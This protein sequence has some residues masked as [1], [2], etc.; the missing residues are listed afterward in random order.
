MQ[1]T[2]LSEKAMLVKLTTRR[3]NLS[4]RDEHAEYII[5][6]Q[7]D[8]ASLVVISRLFRDNNNPVKKVLSTLNE[9]YVYHKKHTLPYTDKGPRILPNALYMDYTAEMRAKRNQL[10]NLRAKVMPNYDQY[11][12]QDIAARSKSTTRAKVE[13]YP[14]AEEFDA[15]VGFDLRFMPL[16]DK[17]HFLFDLSDEDVQNFTQAMVDAEAAAKNDA[18]KRMLEPLKHLVDKL[19]KPIGTEG[20]IFR[21]SA[22]ENVIEGT[23]L[24]KKLLIDPPKELLDTINNLTSAVSQYHSEWLRESPVVREQAT[25]KL[26]DIA[27]QMGAFMG[28]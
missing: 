17:K 1:V 23:E 14:T 9:A 22:I 11:V 26:D 15:R 4:K 12:Q 20:S 19:A 16:P 21:D 8:D 6:Q 3:A 13:D 27:R 24:A 28:A 18:V 7:L 2:T 5:Q 10:D 25:K